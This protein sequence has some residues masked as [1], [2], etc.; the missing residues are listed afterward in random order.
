MKTTR[1]TNRKN[2]RFI[3][4]FVAALCV[5]AL[6]CGCPDDPPVIPGADATAAPSG[7]SLASGPINVTL[8]GSSSTGATSYEWKCSAYTPAAGVALPYTTAQVDALMTNA[9]AA[10]ATVTGLK[11]AGTYKFLLTING[12]AA[13]TKEVTVTIGPKAVT[14]NVGVTFPAFGVNPTVIN[15]NPIYA[16]T[17]GWDSDFSASDI[18]K[19]IKDD[20]STHD[21]YWSSKSDID[22]ARDKSLYGFWPWPPPVF[23]QA[24]YYKTISNEN[25]LGE[26]SFC[27][28]DR[29]DS[30]YFDRILDTSAN[31]ISSL[32]VT[33][34]NLTLSETITELP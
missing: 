11:K 18:V 34:L 10:V 9:N 20:N 32:P 26:H 28:T 31:S 12:D 14:K 29:Y 25:K 16:P 15:L 3:A 19:V 6:F 1:N 21:T 24:F 23:T 17:G 22:V 4:G 5:V 30:G 13:K 33:P 8:N 27:V 2:R 7:T